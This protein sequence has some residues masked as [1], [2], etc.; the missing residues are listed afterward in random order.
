LALVGKYVLGTVLYIDLAILMGLWISVL[1]NK[2]ALNFTMSMIL[3]DLTFD[4]SYNY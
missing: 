1:D 2:V 3:N 4:L